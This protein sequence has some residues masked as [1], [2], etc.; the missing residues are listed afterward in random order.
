MPN[1]LNP[2]RRALLRALLISPLL[3]ACGREAVAPPPRRDEWRN[4][5][6]AVSCTPRAGVAAPATVAEL[7]AALR[8]AQGQVRVVG[9]GH[10]FSPLVPTDHLL[11]ALDALTGVISHDAER[12]T[13]TIAA[14][15]RLFALGEPLAALGQGLPVQPDIDVQSLAGALSTAS[16]GAGPQHHCLPAYLKALS[17]VTASGDLL[18]CSAEHNR[19]LFE[20][21]RVSLGSLGV[22]TQ[23]TLQNRSAYRL[24]ESTGIVPLAEALA[25]I[26]TWKH[27]DRHVEF[28]A[29]AHG[30]TAFLKRMQEAPAGA[31]STVTA[32]ALEDNLLEF[33]A[34]L[35]YDWPW[36]IPTLQRLAGWCVP[37]TVRVG[38]SY[39]IF[40]TI[41][42]TP[43]NEMEYAVPAPRGAE[44]FEE[45]AAT[46][47]REQLPVFFPME[48]RHVAADELWLSP[49]Q[50]RESVTISVHQYHRLPHAAL[51]RRLEPIFWRY[52]GRPHWGKWHSLGAA[53]LATHYPH[54]D[55]FQRLRRQLDPQGTFLNPHLRHLFG[56]KAQA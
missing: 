18:H 30:K 52:G 39:H 32:P 19:E 28:F 25:Q 20:A 1:S 22:L 48:Y 29:F 11:L 37:D 42:Q 24:R 17:L 46:I 35:S 26:E 44:C 8:R 40:P 21:A 13:A 4:W 12:Q 10:S 7:Q 2:Q 6:G 53:Q 38:A 23:V 55:D 41:R 43:F 50:G 3:V 36:L 47:R 9:G 56:E 31:P 5:S 51:F 54:W 45:V 14:G 16:H 27:Q 33:A 49:Y 34:D 15:S